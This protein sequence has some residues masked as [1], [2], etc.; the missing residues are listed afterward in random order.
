VC[1]LAGFWSGKPCNAGE[2][3]RTVRVM[4]ETLACR[5]PDD[6]GVWVDSAAGLAFGFRRLAVLELS[7]LGRQPMVSESGRYVVIFN[8]EIYNF[9]ELR[10][11]LAGLGYQ[12]RGGSDTEVILASVEEW[13]FDEAIPQF[14]GMF[15]IA[16]WDF[17]DRTL[18]LARDHLG[19]K[20]L[21]YGRTGDTLF[22]AS[23]LK[24]FRAIPAFRPEVDP[25]AAALFFR[26]GFIPGPWS[27]YRGVRKLQPGCMVTFRQPTDSTIPRAYWSLKHVTRLGMTDPFRG[28]ECDA[29]RELEILLR[30]SVRRQVVADVPLGVFLSGGIDSSL[31]VALMR[32]RSNAPVRTFTASFGEKG[33]NEA[34]HAIAVVDRFRTDHTELPVT[35]DAALGIIPLLPTIF[36]EPFADASQIPVHLL[37]RRARE[38]VTVCLSGEG[39]DELFGGYTHYRDSP[40]MRRRTDAVPRPFRFAAGLTAQAAAVALKQL[41]TRPALRIGGSL[42]AHSRF[43]LAESEFD[44]I[45][46]H[47]S[48]WSTGAKGITDAFPYVHPLDGSFPSGLDYVDEL[49]FYDNAVGLPDCMLTKVDRAAS[50]VGLEVRVPLLDRGV[51][52]FAWRLRNH[53]KLRRP[54]QGKWILRELLRRYLPEDMADRPKQGFSVPIAA[55]LRGPL[56]DWAESLLTPKRLE[57]SGLKKEPVL[58]AWNELLRSDYDWETL[59]WIVIV[60]QAWRER[61]DHN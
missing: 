18:C 16:L 51:V 22:F 60:Y 44:L 40:A 8:G 32:D 11:E 38:H 59:I 14:N 1:G 58:T 2:L 52:E 29:V 3:T 37:S 45:C 30:D 34:P 20:P 13:G 7:T 4:V 5:G 53:W 61:W 57:E 39:G 19:I 24:A 27:I 17:K 43:L 15:A 49:M 42:T 56:R 36:D 50:S 23:E 46:M 33:F 25:R 54:G 9:Q 35:P 26:H 41:P 6:S 10:C 31:I 48:Y 12:F 28:T 47:N 55:W 21:Y